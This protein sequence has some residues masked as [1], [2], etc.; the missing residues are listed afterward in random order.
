MKIQRNIGGVVF[1]LH[2]DI[3][4]DF[5]VHKGDDSDGDVYIHVPQGLTMKYISG[6]RLVGEG[7]KDYFEGVK[8]NV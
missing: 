5:E 3:F 2:K 6:L 1:A 7:E 8:E 4:A